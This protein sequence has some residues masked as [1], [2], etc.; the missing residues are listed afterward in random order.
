MKQ[1]LHLTLKNKHLLDVWQKIAMAARSIWRENNA[2][3]IHQISMIRIPNV[4][5]TKKKI[6]ASFKTVIYRFEH[7]ILIY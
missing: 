1:Q 2:L 7:Y 4:L 5:Y 3:D 6:P